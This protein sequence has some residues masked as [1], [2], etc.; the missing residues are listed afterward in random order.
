MS[1]PDPTPTRPRWKRIALVGATVGA[2]LL[3]LV[4]LG[5]YLYVRHLNSN[6]TVDHSADGEIGRPIASGSPST[7]AAAAST[8]LPPMNILVM[9]SDTRIGQNGE[10]GSASVYSSAQS[11]VVML[12]HL[13]GDRKRALVMSIPRD[14]WVH[15]PS[16]KGKN[17]TWP[18]MD[19]K[20]NEAFTIGGPA[21]TIKLFKQV[22]GIPIDHFVV[23][24]FNG[25]KQVIDAVGGV[26]LCLNKAMQDPKSHLDLPA[27]PQTVGGEQGLAF[28]RVRHNIGD[29][30]G[31]I[32]RLNRQHLFLG[33]MIKQ[34]QA[35]ATLTNPV[36]LV[37]LLE[38]STK[39]IT[40]DAGLGDLFKL[41]SLAESVAGLQPSKVTFL[42]IPWLDRGD[43]ENVLV[44]TDKFGPIKDAINNDTP[45]PPVGGATTTGGRPLKT[46]PSN[47][48]VRVVNATGKPSTGT[49]VAAALRAQGFNVVSTITSAAK[50]TTTVVQYSAS[51]DESGRT[52]TASVKGA[53]SVVDPSLGSTLELVVGTNYGGVVHVTVA[54]SGPSSGAVTTAD[55][56][57]CI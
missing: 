18:E 6:I 57:G 2:L 17:K 12:V 42:T 31:D 49:S 45:W 47:I 15:I 54:G 22:T 24:D 55:V 13:S 16:C 29:P 44:N 46:A 23:I 14:T 9:G 53:T 41:K 48:S 38:A 7:T 51:R 34:V 37:K 33:A 4:G 25:V 56:S 3:G 11:D 10:G 52:L 32:G 26:K 43:G 40:T 39:A 5:G 36:R 21:C 50:S 20:F 30:T 27:G 35:A 1:T 19:G 8:D 28:L